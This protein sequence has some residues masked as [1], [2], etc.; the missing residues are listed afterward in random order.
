[1]K[2]NSFK[3]YKIGDKKFKFEEAPTY[4]GQDMVKFTLDEVVDMLYEKADDVINMGDVLMLSSE[5]K[6]VKFE[7]NDRIYA[8]TF[9]DYT[10]TRL[11]VE[12]ETYAYIVML[13]VHKLNG[14]SDIMNDNVFAEK[15]FQ[16]LPNGGIIEMTNLLYDA[17]GDIVGEFPNIDAMRASALV[18]AAYKQGF[19]G[20]IYIRPP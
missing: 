20:L 6:L 14:N 10:I 9:Y 1:M 12:P 13:N 16:Y 5:A 11:E 7:L 8:D 18:F 19:W 2:M 15:V 17:Q 3:T 4:V